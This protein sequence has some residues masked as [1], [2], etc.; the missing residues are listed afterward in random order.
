MVFV[1]HRTVEE[2]RTDSN[3]VESCKASAALRR[4]G[5]IQINLMLKNDSQ[6]SS[7]FGNV[8]VC[9]TFACFCH[10]KEFLYLDSGCCQIASI[11]K[12]FL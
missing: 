7:I 6:N 3:P 5:C 8:I 4:M 2:N 12:L 11:C 10:G 1:L 9:L